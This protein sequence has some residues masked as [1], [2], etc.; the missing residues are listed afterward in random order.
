VFDKIVSKLVAEPA[1]VGFLPGRSVLTNARPH[2]G[3]RVVVNFDLAGFFPTIGFPRVRNV[4][5]RIGY[6]Q[7][8]ATMLALLCTECPR[9]SVVFDGRTYHVATGPRGLPQGTY[10][11]PGLSNQVARRLDRRL[12]GLATALGLTYTRYAHDLTFSADQQLDDRV[13]DLPPHARHVARDKGFAVNDA[14]AVHPPRPCANA[15][16]LLL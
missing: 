4:F 6:S 7:C 16:N 1:A 9:S 14:R 10:T 13:G 11:S 8:V 15:T 2:G 5:E 3:R 12:T